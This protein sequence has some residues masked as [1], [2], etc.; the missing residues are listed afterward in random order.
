VREK[1]ERHARTPFWCGCIHAA[2]RATCLPRLPL[3]EML[4]ESMRM[5]AEEGCG[6]VL[7]LHNTSRDS[8]WIALRLCP[9]RLRQ[10]ERLHHMVRR[11]RAAP[12]WFCMRNYGRAKARRPAAGEFCGRSVLAVRSYR[13]WASSAFG[14]CRIRRCIFLPGG[15]R[16]GDRGA[17]GDSGAGMQ[18]GAVG[19]A[20]PRQRIFTVHAMRASCY[21]ARAPL[22]YKVG[23]HFIKQQH[24]GTVK[25][26]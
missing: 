4:D 7:Y 22:F 14:C 24:Q 6:A 2:R 3:P 1:L 20:A 16:P 18:P 23:A 10:G 15:L 13:T 26:P 9:A 12:V 11:S 5:I 8:R 25:M 17:G 21:C 19:W